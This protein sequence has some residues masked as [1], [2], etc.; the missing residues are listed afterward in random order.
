[1][2]LQVD[3]LAEVLARRYL[4]GVWQELSLTPERDLG[5]ELLK[6]LDRCLKP[7]AGKELHLVSAGTGC[8]Y[9]LS[10]LSFESPKKAST[11]TMLSPTCR[12][13]EFVRA[14]DYRTR[15]FLLR[16]EAE[17][18]AGCRAAGETIHSQSLLTLFSRALAP[19]SDERRFEV[20]LLGLERTHGD[21]Q[22]LP[23]ELIRAPSY[24]SRAK[25][26]LD[27]STDA[28]T[29]NT[30]AEAIRGEDLADHERFSEVSSIVYRK[31]ISSARPRTSGQHREDEGRS[32]SED[33]RR[34]GL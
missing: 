14:K 28:E 16:D 21:C 24:R 33:D 34:P 6:S 27:F 2:R 23:A 17:R 8:N 32:M 15:V 9:L 26:P 18:A 19:Q 30:I 12:C 1:M 11:I 7:L 31:S 4:A 3:Q 25:S 5:K 29:L 20:P 10:F 13:S 22:Y